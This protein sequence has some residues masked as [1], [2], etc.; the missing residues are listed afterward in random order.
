MKE[1]F[2]EF[3]D[4]ILPSRSFYIE[5]HLAST[6]IAAHW[7]D[8]VELNLL[9]D[10][11]MTY[12]FDGRQEQVDAGRLVLFWAAIPHQTIRVSVP[13]PLVCIYLPLVDFLALPL[14]PSVRQA[15]MQGAFFKD[16]HATPIHALAAD[17]WLADWTSGKEIRQQLAYE[18]IKLAVRRLCLDQLNPS[19]VSARV[20]HP[21][22]QAVAHTQTLTEAINLRFAEPLTLTALAASANIHPATANRAFRDVLGISMMEY[23]TRYRLARAMQLLVETDHA[24]L[25]IALDVGFG[26]LSRFYDAFKSRSGVTPR[27]FRRAAR[28][29]DTPAIP[30]IASRETQEDE[31]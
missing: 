21:L 25:T 9:L 28:G 20:P 26:S 12:L 18:E 4:W 7:H 10:G 27:Q 17:R 30:Q 19:A 15:V 16:P 6:M 5:R 31:A 13:A 2:S 3:A 22:S 14:D 8:H 29:Q 11:S 24:I 1:D 23:L